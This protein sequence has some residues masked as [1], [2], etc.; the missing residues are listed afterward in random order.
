MSRKSIYSPKWGMEVEI[1]LTVLLIP[2]ECCKALFSG[3]AKRSQFSANS[4]IKYMVGKYI[5]PSHKK[6][7]CLK[8]LLLNIP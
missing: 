8:S 7:T 3:T 1:G 6:E 2:S 4:E 5:P